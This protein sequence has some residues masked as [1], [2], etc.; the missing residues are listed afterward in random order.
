MSTLSHLFNKHILYGTNKQTNQKTVE[1]PATS[2]CSALAARW[3]HHQLSFWISGLLEAH[4]GVMLQVWLIEPFRVPLR[5]N[6]F[7][8]NVK[9]WLALSPCSQFLPWW[10]KSHSESSC[11]WLSRIP[12]SCVDAYKWS[13][14]SSTLRSHNKKEKQQKQ[15]L[16]R[17]FW[18]KE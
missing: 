5:A 9:M 16:L 17:T 15:L 7:L 3:G 10:C 18:I 8:N 2:L 6:Y 14:C 4:C 12:N 13:S 11:W 1:M